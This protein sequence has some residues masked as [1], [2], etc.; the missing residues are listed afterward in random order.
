MDLLG[1]HQIFC[2][3][4]EKNEVSPG[5]ERGIGSSMYDCYQDYLPPHPP[6]C[7]CPSCL[8]A[9]NLPQTAHDISPLLSYLLWHGLGSSGMG[10]WFHHTPSHPS[11][12]LP[13][14]CPPQSQKAPCHLL[15]TPSRTFAALQK[16]RKLPPCAA[17]MEAYGGWEAST[18]LFYT[19]SLWCK[20]ALCMLVTLGG[21]CKW[22]VQPRGHSGLH[23]ETG[24][25]CPELSCLGK[26][27]QKINLCTLA[28]AFGHLPLSSL[29]WFVCYMI[30]EDL[31]MELQWL[32]AEQVCSGP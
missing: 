17:P 28:C 1:P 6:Y 19:P 23:P 11:M 27:G 2:W 3:L 7:L 32:H 22:T 14:A 9:P 13:F 8:H 30:T 21:W 4:K 29:L 24:K 26:Q 18:C 31:K 16:P 12:V 25:S 5:Q 10:M 15:P 20:C